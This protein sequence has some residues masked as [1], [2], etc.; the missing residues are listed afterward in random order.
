MKELLMVVFNSVV[1]NFTVKI[2]FKQV[3]YDLI[4]VL[5]MLKSDKCEKVLKCV[6]RCEKRDV[7][8]FLGQKRLCTQ[9]LR[10]NMVSLILSRGNPLHCTSCHPSLLT[11]SSRSGSPRHLDGYLSLSTVSLGQ[12]LSP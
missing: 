12:C 5:K 7:C 10:T 3:F 11:A 6:K 1:T 9:Y 4:S 2:E 8:F